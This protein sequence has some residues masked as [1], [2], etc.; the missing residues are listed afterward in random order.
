MRIQINKEKMRLFIYLIISALGTW[1]VYWGN[2]SYHT[3][4]NEVGGWIGVISIIIFLCTGFVTLFDPIFVAACIF[5]FAALLI[6]NAIINGGIMI[7]ISVVVIS[8]L[9]VIFSIFNL[10]AKMWKSTVMALFQISFTLVGVM[11]INKWILTVVR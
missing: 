8:I 2:V 9:L 10:D 7:I 6:N 1:L 5:S 3:E 4:G 11:C